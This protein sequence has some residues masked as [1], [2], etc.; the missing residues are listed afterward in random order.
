MGPATAT[1]TATFHSLKLAVRRRRQLPLAK[2]SAR[3]LSFAAGADNLGETRRTRQ[4]YEGLP[5]S[6]NDRWLSVLCGLVVLAGCQPSIGDKCVLSTDCSTRG[7][8]LCDSTQ[9][10]GYCTQFNCRGDDC[11][12]EAVCVLFSGSVPGCPIDDR[13]APP[14]TGRSMCLFACQTDADCRTGDGY[15]CADP[16]GAPYFA[17]GIA[18]NTNKVCLVR[19]TQD[20]GL[21]YSAADAEA[22]V[23]KAGGAT[24]PDIDASAPVEASAPT[25]ASLK[26]DAADAAA[27][28]AGANDASLDASDAAD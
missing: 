21:L 2:Q 20:G 23:C 10:G 1:A 16:R 12:S 5:M 18:D 11:P 22:P 14:R 17:L 7:D 8:R 24:V 15:V 6:R 19:P 3:L 26:P 4:C 27:V 25:D 9:P 28:D 13:H